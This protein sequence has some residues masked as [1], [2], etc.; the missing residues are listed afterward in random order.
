MNDYLEIETKFN[1]WPGNP[2][3]V[4]YLTTCE[5]ACAAWY[6]AWHGATKIESLSEIKEFLFAEAASAFLDGHDDEA[7]L[8]RR[9]ANRIAAWNESLK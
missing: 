2:R 8:L 4:K 6:A 5:A 1:N 7:R 3:N 9:V